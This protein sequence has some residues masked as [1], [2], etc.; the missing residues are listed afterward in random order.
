MVIGFLLV[1]LGIL[2]I[3]VGYR[4]DH[5]VNK[6]RQEI[7]KAL[8]EMK[9]RPPEHT[10]RRHKKPNYVLISFGILF[11]LCGVLSFLGT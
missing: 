8:H 7:I 11:I 10:A 3:I 1:F 6:T 2:F 4:G 5:I 9:G